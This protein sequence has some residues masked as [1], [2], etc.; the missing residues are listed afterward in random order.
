[1]MRRNS[2]PN[3]EAEAKIRNRKPLPASDFRDRFR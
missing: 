1:M 2:K 3:S